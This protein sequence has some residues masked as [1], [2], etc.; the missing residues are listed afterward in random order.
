MNFQLEFALLVGEERRRRLLAEAT[1]WRLLKMRH[2]ALLQPKERKASWLH[3]W[4]ASVR[5]RLIHTLANLRVAKWFSLDFN[6]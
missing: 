3:Q 4:L 5:G 1:Q 2:T 6:L